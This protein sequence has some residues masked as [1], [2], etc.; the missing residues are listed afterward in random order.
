MAVWLVRAGSRGEQENFALENNVVVIG[1]DEL[2]DLSPINSREEMRTLCEQTYP[3]ATKSKISNYTGQLWGF[4]GRIKKGDIV[5][6][7]QKTRSA[8]ALGRVVGEYGF[9]K[10]NPA[11]TKHFRK[12][13]WIRDDV[14]RSHFAQD[15]LY[16]LGAFMTVCQIKRNHIEERIQKILDGSKDPNLDYPVVP[17]EPDDEQPQAIDV[18]EYTLDQ[19]RAYIEAHFRAHELT[20]LVNDVLRA[21]GYHTFMS[22]PGPDG[23]VDIL[24]GQGAMGFENPRL[25]IQVKSGTSPEGVSTLRELQGIM[26]NFKAEQGLL[27]SWSGFK[28]TVY[29]E[30]R[31]LYFSIRLWDSDKLIEAILKNY[32]RLSEGIQAELPLKRIWMMV[33][34]E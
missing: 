4:R 15:F 26:T 8:V 13:E 30:A 27:V 20:R 11:G 23:G 31:T 32:E 12:V 34:E 6:L 10:N 28:D 24:A 1:W 7:P 18:E 5:A 21:Q 9:K 33:P 19:I 29:K 14:P 3:E 22:P 25:C 16:S 2:D 17:I